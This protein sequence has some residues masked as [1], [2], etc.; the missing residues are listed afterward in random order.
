MLRRRRRLLRI[1]RLRRDSNSRQ[2]PLGPECSIQLS[3]R[4]IRAAGRCQSA[5]L[6][7]YGGRGG[8]R[9]PGLRI[10]NPALYPAEL[11]NLTVPALRDPAL[12]ISGPDR[13]SIHEFV[14]SIQ[15]SF[16][17]THGRR[18]GD[19]WWT[20]TTDLPLRRRPLSSTELKGLNEVGYSAIDPNF[21]GIDPDRIWPDTLFVKWRALRDSNS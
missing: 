21:F 1:W 16:G 2:T 15:T 18:C 13:R 7:V 19:P 14:E 17:P 8:T 11:R 20:R 3:Y 6:G 10:R 12:P 5:R 4:G 9:I